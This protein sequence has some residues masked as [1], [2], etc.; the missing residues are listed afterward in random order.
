MAT[1]SN[2]HETKHAAI[3]S[4]ALE[5]FGRDGFADANVDE[6]ARRAG[7]AKPTIYNRFGDKRALFVEAMKLGMERAN[8]RIMDV[9]QAMDARPADL[10]AELERLGEA[11]G[12][13]VTSEEGGAIVRVQVADAARF[14]ELEG[15][16]QRERHIDA[17]A[18]KLAQ[19]VA[20]GYLRMVD[21]QVA[22][23]QFM[24][25]TTAE[26][27]NMSG[28]GRRP[29]AR[30]ALRETVAAGVETF[31]AAFGRGGDA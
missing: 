22:A 13:C 24:V 5:V 1:M 19:L 28:Y 20:T 8:A 6:I 2:T 29:L 9:I 4:S 7:V 3:L 30:K 15:N 18:G 12:E 26:A 11:L 27:L 17:L 31:L 25:L 23:R 16:N 10:K 21:P 14:P